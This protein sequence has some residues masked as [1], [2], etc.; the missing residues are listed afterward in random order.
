[1]GKPG[2]SPAASKTGTDPRV[3][4]DRAMKSVRKKDANLTRQRIL[5]AATMEFAEHGYSGGRIDRIIKAAD[6]NVRMLYH[7]FGS[8]EVL[9]LAA[10]EETYRT[11]RE[12]EITLGMEEAHPVEGMRRLIELTFDFLNSD[13]F[14]V[15]L[16]MSEN[17]MKGSIIRK[18]KAVP[19]MTQPLLKSLR[20]LVHR[21]QQEGVFHDRVD[22]ESLYMS[23][24]GLSIIQVSNRYT[25]SSMFQHDVG[26]PE[27]L[28]PR[29]AS[30]VEM[31]ISYLTAVNESRDTTTG[32]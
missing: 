23:I 20:A 7:Y 11:I 3:A 10:L 12:S 22:P 30:V 31:V 4:P 19:E 21:G 8:K 14:F 28:R 18:S 27:L 15:R 2:I 24:L 25:L 6:V 1:M 9:Y 5:H 17:L 29:K 26:D 32:H 16:I 13:P